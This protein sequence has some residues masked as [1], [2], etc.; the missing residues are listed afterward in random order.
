[1]VRN[2]NSKPGQYSLS[3]HDG[4]NVKHYRI[5]QLDKGNYYLNRQAVFKSIM[6]LVDHHSK[7]PDGLSTALSIPCPRLDQPLTHLSYNNWEI[8]RDSI[9]FVRRLGVGSCGEVWEGKW[10]GKIVVAVKKHKPGTIDPQS[11]LQEAAMM[12][13]LRHP[14]LVQLYG[15]CTQ[16]EPLLIIMELMS[17]GSLLEYL[18]GYGRSLKLP[19]LIDMAAQVAAG[20]AYLEEQKY[21]HRDL[22][23]RNVLVGENMICKV[24]NFGLAR[25]IDE[26]FYEAP[27]GT[28]LPVKWTALEA[29][30]Y[31]RYT[32]KTD[33]WSFGIVIY[34]I[35]TYGRFP[36]PGMTNREVL[37]KVFDGYRM[38]CPRNCPQKLHDI[39]LDCWRHD[40]GSRPTF[41]SLQWTLE[42]FFTTAEDA[43]YREPKD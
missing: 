2:S 28:K 19:Q 16:E 32:I 35:I 36:Y 21:I 1:M 5:H 42:E 22:A 33:I 10:N 7:T 37:E 24:A 9:T 43:S 17:H 3:L 41:K 31:N 12:K 8:S 14:K 11:F 4:E 6:E 23:A 13:K 40:P 15:V 26:H 27:T 34:E 29:A 18:R 30:L 39:M 38:P 25:M 20:M